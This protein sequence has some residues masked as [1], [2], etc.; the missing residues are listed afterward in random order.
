MPRRSPFQGDPGNVLV[1]PP[2]SQ[3]CVSWRAFPSGGYLTVYTKRAGIQPDMHIMAP[4]EEYENLPEDPEIAFAEFVQAQMNSYSHLIGGADGEDAKRALKM[5]FVKKIMGFQKAHSMKIVGDPALRRDTGPF[6]T[7]F[8]I[9]WD[10]LI[11]VTTEIGVGHAYRLRNIT[12]I[13]HLPDEVRESIHSKIEEIRSK[14]IPL[15]LRDKK[16][17]ALLNA[18][19][20]FSREVDHDRTKTEAWTSFSLE[21][22][23][24]G[25]ELGK[26]AKPIRDLMDSVS[27]ALGK[28]KE[29]G[30]MLGL[31]S[32]SDKPKQIEGPK[33]QLPKPENFDD[34]DPF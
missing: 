27:S 21:M 32:S 9:F 7:H 4:I 15:N 2:N 8:D 29:I 34:N 31:P 12:T 22:A 17:E 14:I 30:E 6:H 33:K 20:A 11:G 18:L 3:R 5:L 26:K 25:E 19:A 1:V 24:V 16:K 13:L 10:S 28:V 23:T